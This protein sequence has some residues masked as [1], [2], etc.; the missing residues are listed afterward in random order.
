MTKIVVIGGGHGQSIILKGIK[1]IADVEISA[2]VT[3]ADDGGSTGRL[4]QRYHLPAMG[5][6][7]KGSAVNNRRRTFKRLNEIRRKRILEQCRHCACR[8]EVTRGDRLIVI[9]ISYD[10]I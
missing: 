4:R 9:S 3:V 7:R 1:E 5:D 2:I 8:F 10:Y 6:I